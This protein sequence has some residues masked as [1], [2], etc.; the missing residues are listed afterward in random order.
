MS[1]L[2]P[3]TKDEVLQARTAAKLTQKEAADLIHTVGTRWSEWEHGVYH[4]RPP[5]WELFLLKTGQHPQFILTK[6]G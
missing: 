2:S 4:M 3:P 5:S 6:R 1:T